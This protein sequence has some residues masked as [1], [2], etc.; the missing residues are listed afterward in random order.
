MI[1]EISDIFTL[2]SNHLKPPYRKP[3]LQQALNIFDIVKP[4]FS[5]K[6]VLPDFR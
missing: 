2:I 6:I 1:F 5:G 4:T 3:I